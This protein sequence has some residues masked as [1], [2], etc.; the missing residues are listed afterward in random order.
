[1]KMIYQCSQ[2]GKRGLFLP[3]NNLGHCEMCIE[4][5]KAERAR[6]NAEA[7]SVEN[8][9][10]LWEDA[11]NGRLSLVAGAE[12]VGNSDIRKSDASDKDWI[13]ALLLCIFLGVFGVHRFYVDKPLT[14]V[15]YMLTAGCLGIGIIIDI[16][17]IASGNFTDG[18]GAIILSKKQQDRL[19]GS[20]IQ[21]APSSD[22][23]AQL[24]KLGELR[25]SGILTDEEFAEKK[26][27][28]LDKIK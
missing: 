14:A 19:Y 24:R 3:L 23:I 12:I 22:V 28:L 27:V 7:I 11:K 15:L 10:P 5:N 9:T 6:H 2:C 16:C 4:K 20:N 17:S 18:S 13:T 21:A 1:M 8:V 25:N 26:A